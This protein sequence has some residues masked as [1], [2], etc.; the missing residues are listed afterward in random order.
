[1]ALF[2]ADTTEPMF[3]AGPQL[4]G[5]C[6]IGVND[7]SGWVETF[8]AAIADARRSTHAV[9]VS[10][11]WGANWA[12]SPSDAKR[13]LGRTLI[14]LGADVVI[15]ANAH[16]LQGIEL[17]GDGVI[18]HDVAHAAAPFEN[19]VESALFELT[20][21]VDGIARVEIEPIMAETNRSRQA[22]PAERRAILERLAE[23]S[24]DLGTALTGDT[25]ELR[26]SP[27]PHPA[28]APERVVRP[29]PEAVIEP[30]DEPPAGCAV[31][32]V[33]TEARLE[34]T[35]LGP[36]T[37][38]GARPLVDGI[39][40]PELVEVETYWTISRPVA[41]DVRLAPGEVSEEGDFGGWSSEH[42]PCDWAWPTSRWQP[43]VIYR[44]VAQLRPPPEF[45]TGSGA[46]FLASGL[47]GSLGV[48]IGVRHDGADLGRSGPIAEVGL[49][50]SIELRLILAAAAILAAGA[51]WR[52]RVRRRATIRRKS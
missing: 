16:A 32:A 45:L 18:L 36:L 47:S 52:W 20:L 33:P 46:A 22:S 19:P 3:A 48:T 14:D 40:L 49:G 5:T 35:A 27:R 9:L 13:E 23:R 10:M 41:I 4:A 44:D 6:H 39:L 26:F 34:P 29:A 21:S 17:H 11:H 7:I 2:S 24:A 51:L 30:A 25:L 37:L 50:A 42:D 8:E 1:M 43:D 31:D 38:I 12:T 28:S 15:G